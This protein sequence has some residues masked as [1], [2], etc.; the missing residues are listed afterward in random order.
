ML[1]TR[2]DVT[3]APNP[4]RTADELRALRDGLRAIVA[5]ADAAPNPTDHEPLLSTLRDLLERAGIA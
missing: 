2:G 1:A 4:G 3:R 5:S